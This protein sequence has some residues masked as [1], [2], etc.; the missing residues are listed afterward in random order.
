MTG[1]FG[2][3]AAPARVQGGG[4]AEW[5]E[6][7]LVY[8]EERRGEACGGRTQAEAEAAMEGDGEQR[9]DEMPLLRW[10]RR[11]EEGLGSCGRV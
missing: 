8:M 10:T 2:D 11:D 9:R 7:K 4:V 6:G 5:D 1:F 3:A